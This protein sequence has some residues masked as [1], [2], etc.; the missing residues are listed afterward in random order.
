MMRTRTLLLRRFG[1]WYW[2][3]KHHPIPHI[4]PTN[5][6]KRQRTLPSRQLTFARSEVGW[7]HQPPPSSRP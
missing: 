3:D 1:V 7:S 5:Q 6:D 2:Q 4:A